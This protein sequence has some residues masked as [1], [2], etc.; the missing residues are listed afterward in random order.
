MKKI[1]LYTCLLLFFTVPSFC[2]TPKVEGW[3]ATLKL[4]LNALFGNKGYQ[5]ETLDL[6]VEWMKKKSNITVDFDFYEMAESDFNIAKEL[7]KKK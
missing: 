3:E 4:K 2:M 1:T 6:E 7:R 5:F